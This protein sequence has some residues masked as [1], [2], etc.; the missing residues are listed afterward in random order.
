[1]R[2]AG[3]HRRTYHWVEEMNCKLRLV[4]PCGVAVIYRNWHSSEEI[5]DSSLNLTVIRYEGL[6]TCPQPVG[7]LVSFENHSSV[8]INSIDGGGGIHTH[9][10]KMSPMTATLTPGEQS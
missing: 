10:M 6:Q 4:F 3:C 1:M 8:K 2:E 9:V 5:S 7:H